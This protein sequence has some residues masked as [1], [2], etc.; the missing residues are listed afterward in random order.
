MKT[1]FKIL[2]AIALT[3]ACVGLMAASGF[4][5][6]P[7]FQSVG[8]NSTPPATGAITASGTI[9][10]NAVASTTT[11]SAG[12]TVSGATITQSGNQVL[13]TTSSLPA[14]NLTGSI[15]DARLSAN[16]PLLNVS[17][18][19]SL[20]AAN[21]ILKQINTNAA[22]NS[23]TQIY[24][25]NDAGR[26][27]YFGT[28]SSASS[29]AVL[30]GGPT[31]EQGFISY[32][33]NFPLTIGTNNTE[34]IRI[35]GAGASINLKATAIQGN[36]I[37]MTPLTGTFTMT[38]STGCTTTPS[39]TVT[40]AMIGNIVTLS[41]PGGALLFNCTGN[42]ANRVSDASIPAAIRPS[43]SRAVG[44]TPA[45]DNGGTAQSACVAITSAGVMFWEINNATSPRT[46]TQSS[47]WTSSGSTTA[48]PFSVTYLRN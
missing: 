6:R 23:S 10:G 13:D 38:L 35:D 2:S 45:S 40:Y 4:P 1:Q 34:R 31:T 12:T 7:R 37:D 20:S 44:Y 41:S 3:L 8:V 11:V 9:T 46:C 47:T 39:W 15:A 14:A 32:S 16:V 43:S 42:A 24:A 26:V 33:G 29:I 17:N 19:F 22:A 30:T 48:A 25:Q 28:N 27:L 21:A 36:G 5:S 18:T